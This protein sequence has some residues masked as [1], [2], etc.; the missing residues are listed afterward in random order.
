MSEMS[1]NNTS[2]GLSEEDFSSCSVDRILKQ[3]MLL[4][5]ISD[6]QYRAQARQDEFQTLLERFNHIQESLEWEIGKVEKSMVNM[7]WLDDFQTYI[8]EFQAS[9]TNKVSRLR[10]NIKKMQAVA[11]K[12]ALLVKAKGKPGKESLDAKVVKSIQSLPACPTVAEIKANPSAA[13]T[14]SSNLIGVL[15]NITKSTSSSPATTRALKLSTATI[16]NLNKAFQDRCSEIRSLKTPQ[17]DSSKVAKDAYRDPVH[18][19]GSAVQQQKVPKPPAFPRRPKADDY[20]FLQVQDSPVREA[21]FEGLPQERP[22]ATS[23]KAPKDLQRPSADG[24]FP[25]ATPRAFALPK[26]AQSVEETKVSVEQKE[27]IP[28]FEEMMAHP[29]PVRSFVLPES[30]VDMEPMERTSFEE[31]TA[32]KDLQSPSSRPSHVRSFASPQTSRYVEETNV[33]GVQVEERHSPSP[34]HTRPSSAMKLPRLQTQ[35][36]DKPETR[37]YDSPVSGN[38]ERQCKKDSE[39]DVDK[40]LRARTYNPSIVIDVKAQERNL[41]QLDRSFENSNISSE[42]YNLCRG[43]VSQTLQSV[44]LRL[45]CLLRRYIRH[46]QMKQLRKTLDEN[47]KETRNLKDGLEFKKVHSQLCKFDRFQQS[48]K[49]IWDAE[50]ASADETR[51]LCIARTAHL[52]QQVNAMHGLHLTGIASMQKHVSLP[53][54]T[55]TPVRFGCPSP[56]QKPQT[57][58][59]RASTARHLQIHPKALHGIKAAR[60]VPGSSLKISRAQCLWPV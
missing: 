39:E 12:K 53:L 41:Q 8:D 42:M 33:Y 31:M 29:S 5:K 7:E 60:N 1:L 22:V 37:K 45:G 50:Q 38:I 23:D 55:V 28:A 35:K 51:R 21:N 10:E 49:T 19:Y 18:Q 26:I 14:Y 11:A 52:F 27:K 46:V 47:F 30:K 54:L 2:L 15:N 56:P 36:S 3:Q 58:P 6:L 17:K 44:E 24:P 13:S 25:P 9:M 43:T 32:P 48:V 34:V 40:L 16:E 59:S 4:N 20:A 57:A